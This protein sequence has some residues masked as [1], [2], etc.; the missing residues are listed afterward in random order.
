MS[1]HA[2]RI[3]CVANQKG[4]VGKTTTT[5]NLAAGLAQVLTRPLDGRDHFCGNEVVEYAPLSRGVDVLPAY[6]LGHQFKGAG[7]GTT[8]DDPNCRSAFVGSFAL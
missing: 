6:T 2:P 5:V 7:L 3:F 4:G 1:R 8:W